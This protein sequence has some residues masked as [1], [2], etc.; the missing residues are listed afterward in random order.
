MGVLTREVLVHYTAFLSSLLIPHTVNTPLTSHTHPTHT[1]GTYQ[2]MGT[3]MYLG[4]EWS[5]N[6]IHVEAVSYLTLTEA[7]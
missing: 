7:I 3:I 5:D 6:F 4:P 1:I 2:L